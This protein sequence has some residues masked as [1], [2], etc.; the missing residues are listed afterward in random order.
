MRNFSQYARANGSYTKIGNEIGRRFE[1]YGRIQRKP[2]HG[3]TFFTEVKP[4]SPQ[5]PVLTVWQ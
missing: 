2:C 5:K 4:G 1:K 3:A